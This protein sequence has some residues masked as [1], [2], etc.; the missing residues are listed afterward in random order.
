VV[1]GNGKSFLKNPSKW[2]MNTKP[3]GDGKELGSGADKGVRIVEGDDP[4]I[5]AVPVVVVD[6]RPTCSFHSQLISLIFSEESRLLQSAEHVSDGG[7]DAT[8][9]S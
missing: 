8:N 9:A 4:S 5:D 6:S 1:F 3:L 7:R 2:H